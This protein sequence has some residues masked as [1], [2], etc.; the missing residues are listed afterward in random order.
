[1]AD[2][3]SPDPDP[4]TFAGSAL[5]FLQPDKPVGIHPDG[6]FPAGIDHE[7]FPFRTGIDPVPGIIDQQLD[8]HLEIFTG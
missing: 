1:M 2:G 5:E 6:H 8:R 4:K 3:P 7:A